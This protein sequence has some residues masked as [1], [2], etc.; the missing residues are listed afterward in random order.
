V[1]VPASA[2][3]EWLPTI[4]GRCAV[5][6]CGELRREPSDGESI[7]KLFGEPGRVWQLVSPGSGGL[8]NLFLGR[9]ASAGCQEQ[10]T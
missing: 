5:A 1:A 4:F 10:K 3:E 8:S 6:G 2:L 7:W 9:K